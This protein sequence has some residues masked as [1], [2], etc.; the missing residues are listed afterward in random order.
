VALSF[1][2]L[3]S[4]L[5]QKKN[6]YGNSNISPRKNKIYTSSSALAN[7]TPIILFSELFLKNLII[8]SKSKIYIVKGISEHL[9]IPYLL[10]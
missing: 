6:H 8:S 5:M 2:H 9:G 3:K 1:T 4:I 10:K 7:S